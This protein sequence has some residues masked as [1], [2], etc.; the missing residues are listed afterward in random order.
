MLT[1]TL[2]DYTAVFTLSTTGI[3]RFLLLLQPVD[4]ERQMTYTFRVGPVD[5]PAN[6]V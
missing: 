5:R 1:I 4:R 6:P 3:E 2:D